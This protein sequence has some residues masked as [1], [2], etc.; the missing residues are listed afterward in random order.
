MNCPSCGFVNPPNMKFC[1]QCGTKL[2]V[3]CWRCG[4]VV[5]EGFNFCGQCGAD[6]RNPEPAAVG[7]PA[8]VAP[9]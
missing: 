9:A 7:V 8:A 1:G 3:S 6:Q 4:A 2:P 5:P